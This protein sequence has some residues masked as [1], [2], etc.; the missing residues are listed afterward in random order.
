MRAGVK[1]V[2]LF[3]GEMATDDRGVIR[4]VDKAPLASLKRLYVV[5]NFSTSTIRAW[6]GHQRE[7]KFVAVLHGAALVAVVRLTNPHR[8]S[9]ASKPQRFVLSAQQSAL[10][11]IPPGYANGWRAL[12]RGT[13]ILFL[14]TATAEESKVDDIR[15]PPN[16]WGSTVWEV[17][18][19]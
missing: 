13:S 1:H 16:Y 15:F 3:V 11:C 7:T 10:L 14:S 18:D 17:E 4:F 6:H 12:A 2:R 5:E 8:P 19:R 9:K